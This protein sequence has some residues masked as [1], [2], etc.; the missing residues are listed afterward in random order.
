[1]KSI[2]ISVRYSLRAIGRFIARRHWVAIVWSRHH[3]GPNSSPSQSSGHFSGVS[4][5]L[6]E[7]A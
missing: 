4:S 3:I 2:L 6:F 5:R 1:M 7:S